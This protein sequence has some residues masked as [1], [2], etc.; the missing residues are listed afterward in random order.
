MVR[1]L[2]ASAYAHT[3]DAQTIDLCSVAHVC[4]ADER[5]RWLSFQTL[6]EDADREHAE[7]IHIEPDVDCWRL[8]LRGPFSFTEIRLDHTH[9]FRD[10]LTLLCTYMW[11][12]TVQK[13]A[14]RG[15]FGFTLSSVPRLIQLD[16]VPSSRGQTYLITLLHAFKSPPAALDELALNR[17]QQKQVRELLQKPAGLILLASDLPQGRARTARAMAQAIVSPDKKVICGDMPGH[18]LLSRTTQLAIDRPPSDEQKKSWSSMCQ[19]GADAIVACQSMDDDMA[20]YLL[21]FAAEDT[22]VIQ[23]VGVTSAADAVD[24]LL[25]FGIRPEAIA[26]TL[27]AII[28]Q[29]RVQCLCT[30]CRVVSVPDDA[31]TAWLAHYSPIKGNNINDWLRHR[32]RSSFSSATGCERCEHTGLDTTRD[33]FDI[34]TLSDDV[35]DAL[36]DADVRYALALLRSHD[37]MASQ[38]LKLAQEGIISV[39]EA[40]RIQPVLKRS[41]LPGER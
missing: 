21:Q 38:V 27:M 10:C 33:I 15:W 5:E 17:V 1:P 39:A 7:E 30:Y 3:P 41:Y 28:V 26:R 18:P 24:R 6:L 34:V 22:L 20:A 4:P 37:A 29:R 23:S 14:L 35:V 31:D 8:R 12:E 13:Q 11:G 32:M 2:Y 25:S 36:Y 9:I 40:G 19:M 16:V